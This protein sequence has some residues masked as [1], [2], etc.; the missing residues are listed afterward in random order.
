PR[1]AL[2]PYTTLFRSPER[3]EK[4]AQRLEFGG[5]VDR[6]TC[7]VEE[8]FALAPANLAELLAVV[9]IHRRACMPGEDR[10]PDRDV[11]ER[12]IERGGDRKSTRLNSSHSQ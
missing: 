9:P 10:C 3:A 2:F 11:I 1:A 7:V 4:F 5:V 6:V 12:R 8:S